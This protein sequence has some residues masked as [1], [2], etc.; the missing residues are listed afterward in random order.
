MGDGHR[1]PPGRGRQ[2]Q[3]R[4]VGVGAEPRLGLRRAQR[5]RLRPVPPVPVR[6]GP[7]GRARVQQLP[8][9]DRVEP[10]R[11]RGGPVL[12]RRPRPL[13][14]ACARPASST[15]STPRSPSTTS[16]PRGGPPPTAA[17][18]TRPSSTASA[19][20]ARWPTGHLG[21]LITRACTINEPNIVSFLG[22]YGG[23]F[24]P[25]VARSRPLAGGQRPLRGRPPAGRRGAQAPAAATSRSASRCPMSD[26]QAVPARRRGTPWR[27]SSG[28]AATPRTCSS[29]PAAG[30]D[31]VGV[32]S[33]SRTRVVRRRQPRQP[34]TGVDVAGHGLRVL[35]RRSSTPPSAGP[36]SS[37]GTCPSLVTENGIGTDDDD[38]RIALCQPAPSTACWTASTT[39]S[40]CRATR[41]GAP[42]TTSSG[43]SAT[44]PASAWSRSTGPPSS[45]W[46]SPA[47]HWLGRIARANQLVD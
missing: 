32:Q 31:F 11:A 39:A 2:R 23:V 16:P 9:L 7:A 34:R 15:A 21:D 20:S 4:L 12:G 38:Q 5:R 46:S 36:G 18:R 1:R 29:R 45:G 17:G 40:T 22:Y 3:Q 13:P 41:T 14:A 8:L 27:G 35:A 37:P 26:Y 47:A 42:S 10:H 24:P 28:C 33:Y 25:G 6:P 44:G 30:D 43:P 19:A